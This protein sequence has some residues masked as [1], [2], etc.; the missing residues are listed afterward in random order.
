MPTDNKSKLLIG[1]NNWQPQTVSTKR[2]SIWFKIEMANKKYVEEYKIFLL[3][4]RAISNIN[5]TS[6]IIIMAAFRFLFSP[7]QNKRGKKW[8]FLNY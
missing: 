8:H 6:P 7:V 5:C 4:Q 1:I 2:R 3:P